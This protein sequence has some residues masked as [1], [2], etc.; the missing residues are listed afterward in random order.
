MSVVGNTIA[1]YEA[2]K[3]GPSKKDLNKKPITNLGKFVGTEMW[4][5]NSFPAKSIV[6]L[7]KLTEEFE[8]SIDSTN[9]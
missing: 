1:Y 2:R 5:M 9:N 7:M 3:G 8:D 6:E 4:S